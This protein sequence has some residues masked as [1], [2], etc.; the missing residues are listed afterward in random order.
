MFCLLLFLGMLQPKAAWCWDLLVNMIIPVSYFVA[1]TVN[2]AV[3]DAPRYPITL[4][5]LT[6]SA[7]I[8]AYAGAFASCFSQNA[9]P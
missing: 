1:F 8:A 9:H 5:V 3:V 6:I 2:Y 4:I 7:L